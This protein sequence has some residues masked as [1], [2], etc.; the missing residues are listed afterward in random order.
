MLNVI[1]QIC[2]PWLLNLLK[3]ITLIYSNTYRA[4]VYLVGQFAPKRLCQPERWCHQ[5]WKLCTCQDGGALGWRRRPPR[6]APSPYAAPQGGSC[7]GDVRSDDDRWPWPTFG[8]FLVFVA[9][10]PAA[11]SCL[12]TRQRMKPNAGNM[13]PPVWGQINNTDL[14]FPN[15]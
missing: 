14:K 3:N 8:P 4:T 12:C 9:T 5:C 7:P 6:G 10:H 13:L 2:F 1:Y 11:A 15:Y